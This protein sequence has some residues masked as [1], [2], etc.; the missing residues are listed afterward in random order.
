MGSLVLSG[1]ARSFGDVVAVR[2]VSFT[3]PAGT[4]FGL[5]GPNGAGK[6]TTM[7]MILGILVPDRGTIRWDDVPVDR[8]VRRRFGYLPEERGLYG[9]LKVRDQ[10]A[11]FGRLH[12]VRPPHDVTRANQWIERL[13]L[14]TYADRPCAELSKGNQQKVQVACAALHDP[15]LLVLDEPFSGLDPVNA[16]TLL[17]TLAE[18]QARGTTLILSSHQ[19]WQVEDLCTSVCVIAG[20]AVKVS[21]TLAEL[22]AAWP[23]RVVEVEPANDVLRAVLDTTAGAHALPR[24]NGK[25]AYELPAAADP[26]ALLRR[27]VDAGDVVRFERLEPSL[28]DI[29]MRATETA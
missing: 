14:S 12:G 10:I 18:L 6:T 1:V 4:T 20:G 7:R 26:A 11:Y 25:L 5:L 3:V 22:R 24:T 19:M 16:E 28:R 21:G 23:T 29:Y 17:K 8:G 15:E 9:A 13:G 2:D 27:L